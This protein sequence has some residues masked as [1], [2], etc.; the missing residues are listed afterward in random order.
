MKKVI[1]LLTIPTLLISSFVFVSTVH[2]TFD[3]ND[4]IDDAIFNDYNS[5]DAAQINT[6]LNSNFPTSCISTN[7]GFSAPDP[8][9]Y[10]PTAGFTYGADVSAGQVISDAA[11]AYSINPEVLLVTMEK[12]QSLVTGKGASGCS[13]LAYTGAMGY[14]CPD[15]G[16]EYSYSGENLYS[17]NGVVV[18]SVNNTCVDSSL[19]AGFSQQVIHAAWLLKF[20]EERS[21]GD[22]NWDVQLS[23]LPET[24]DVWNNSDDPLSCYG[25]PMTQGTWQICP[26]GTT[27][28]YDGYTTIDGTSIEIDNGATAA[29]YWYTPHTS[30]NES[31]Y[32]VFTGWFGDT[33]L[34]C[35]NNETMMPQVVE[36]YNSQNYNQVYTAYACEVNVLG[37]E[38][39]YTDEGPAFNT[40][41][42][43]LPGAQPVYQLYNPTTGLYFWTTSATELALVQRQAGYTLSG[44]AFYVAP[45]NA[46]GTQ[47]VYRLYNP[48]TYMHLWSLVPGN[49]TTK[50]AGYT[51]EG[52]A[53]Y[54]Q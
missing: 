21:E 49:A 42:P 6:W 20:G 7:N 32:N 48:K 4:L 10:T 1:S 17:I 38:A 36:M 15:G 33:L 11:Q 27:T 29:L 24:G 28:Y 51:L 9:G 35:T 45:P 40:S 30:G 43:Q 39:G 22:V 26:Q 46:T 34:G 19:Q 5:M 2:A 37:Y 44:I 52:I 47:P 16:T 31:F 25:G 3:P 41:S 23:N 8:T 14:G 53:F 18:S 12:E 13:T 50:Q 54:S